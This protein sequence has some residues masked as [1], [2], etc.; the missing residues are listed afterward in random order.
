MN[1]IRMLLLGMS[2]AVAG[3]A[4]AA[5]QDAAPAPP[6]VLQITREWVKPGKTGAIHDKSE[7]AF[8]AASSRGKLQGHYIAVNS[9][10]GKARAL[11]MFRYPSFAA[12]EQDQKIIDKS[13]TLTAEFDRAAVA[14]GELLDGIDTSVFVYNPEWSYHPHPDL[15][16]A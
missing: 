13:A 14:D 8:L 9:I 2:L 12:M 7:A 15:S 16:H 4:F 11:Y 1:N 3:S 5:A 6:N 10:S